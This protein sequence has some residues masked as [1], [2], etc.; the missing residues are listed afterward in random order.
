MKL[1]QSLT[2][3]SKSQTPQDLGQGLNLDPTPIDR[4]LRHLS[5]GGVINKLDEDTYV[6]N[7]L[8]K[9]LAVAGGGDAVAYILEVT[10]PYFAGIPKALVGRK[11][12]PSS[13]N[14]KSLWKE[15]SGTNQDYY[16]WLKDNPDRLTQFDAMVKGFAASR[17]PW[18]DIYPTE[19]LFDE[20]DRDAPILVDVGG[21]SGH[22]IEL[23]RDKH[24]EASGRL[25]LQDQW[26]VVAAAQTGRG[27]Q[28]MVHDFFTPQPV[29]GA[30]V[31]FLHS[32]LHNWPDGKAQEILLNL[33]SAMRN[34][35]SKVLV[36]DLVIRNDNPSQLSCAIDMRMLWNFGSGERSEREWQ[37]LFT[38]VGMRILTT[39]F[40]ARDGASV[41]EVEVDE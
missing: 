15:A 40:P 8:T 34:G 10:F 14:G 37:R 7:S 24:L 17:E 2:H 30:R 35:R 29:C 25:I 11:W 22:D 33:K 21:G 20:D 26:E 3:S 16:D 28:K 23:F 32:V 1:L 41:I 36:H 6:A 4:I 39:W 19:Q 9:E 13:Q 31:Y 27:I 5:T 38:S 12:D 18:V